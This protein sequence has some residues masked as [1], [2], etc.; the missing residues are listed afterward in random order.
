MVKYN[1]DVMKKVYLDYS[2]TTMVDN[3]VL[4]KFNELV[5]ENYANPNS[6]HDF[7]LESKSIIDES[8]NN[9]CS[10]FN[11]NKD[12]IIFTSGSSESNNTVIKGII[13]GSSR[14]KIITTYLEHSSIIS[15]LSYLQSKGY[16]VEFVKINNE[17]LIDIEDLKSK[18]D[19]NTLL[20]SIA[21]VDSELGTLLNTGEVFKI[22]KEYDKNIYTHSDITQGLG[23]VNINLD[24]IDMASFSG[25]KIYS[26]KGIGG[27]IKKDN[28]KIT[29]L[30]HGGRSTTFYRSG[31]P[32]TELI[33]SLSCAFDL[34]KDRID[35][36]YNYVSELNNRV[37]CFLNKYDNIII[38][39]TENSIPHILNFSI[40][41]RNSNDTQKYFNDRNIYISTK[42]ACSSDKNM[43]RTVFN[44]YKDEERAISSVRISLSYKT[45][46]EEIDY[47]L[48]VLSKYMEE[49]YENIKNN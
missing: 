13:D 7:G 26:F 43:S 32:S 16:I 28:I 20:V 42:S 15:P 27:L 4:E 44:M 10:Y 9:I 39:S 31:T 21:Y 49:D 35:E 17:G 18:L 38:N 8:I 37:R 30:I 41:G 12:E 25:H 1:C 11:I 46:L 36:R 48:K 33:Y 29:P 19:D 6:I 5:K 47:L 23:K 34:F 22:V 2:A 14:K 40:I 45:T 24:N 3:Y